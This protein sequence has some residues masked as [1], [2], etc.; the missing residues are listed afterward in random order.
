MVECQ[1]SI[2]NECEDV[3]QYNVE[4]SLPVEELSFFLPIF[5]ENSIQKH[6]P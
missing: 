1:L 4:S 5:I 2:E 3:G 6:N